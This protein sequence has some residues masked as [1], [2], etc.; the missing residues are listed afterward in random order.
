M[1]RF[2][3]T[4]YEF[5]FLHEYYSD[6]ETFDFE[7]Y[8]LDNAKNTARTSGI[9]LKTTS[10]G[11]SLIYQQKGES[12]TDPYIELDETLI[13]PLG[14]R[15]LNVEILQLTDLPTKSD[16]TDLFVLSGNQNDSELTLEALPTR[17][18]SFVEKYV[19]TANSATFKLE[20]S[21]GNTI[22]KSTQQ[23]I[24]DPDTP[25]NFHYHF[26]VDLKSDLPIG[27]YVLKTLINGVVEDATEVIIFNRYQYSNLWA[28]FLLSIDGDV[29]YEELPNESNLTFSSTAAKWVYNVMLGRDFSGGTISIK[30]TKLGDP[31]LFAETSVLDDYIKGETVVF[32]SN[33]AITKS[34]T[35]LTNFQL[36][37]ESDETELTINKLPNPA[38]NQVN[39]IVYLKI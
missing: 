8:P 26:S 20:D 28:L 27:K 9:L 7:V 38:H 23:G 19:Y 2:F 37:A 13:L 33:Q 14:I 5:Q 34:D 35:P 1:E 31:V 25:T 17:P 21:S 3:G 18:Y 12:D 15:L 29:D 10:K 32:E 36:V 24:K 30:N 4:Y 16:S 22:L 39:S 11:F 6:K